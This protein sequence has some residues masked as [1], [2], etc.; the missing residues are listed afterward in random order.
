MIPWAGVDF[1]SSPISTVAGPCTWHSLFWPYIPAAIADG[2][3]RFA[4]GSG[5]THTG[6][7]PGTLVAPTV[8]TGGLKLEQL[9]SSGTWLHGSLQARLKRCESGAK[10]QSHCDG[11][12]HAIARSLKVFWTRPSQS[13]CN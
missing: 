8:P 2:P 3:T 11:Y 13:A 7:S 4:I 9:G 12:P 5:T 1:S 10:S 6:V